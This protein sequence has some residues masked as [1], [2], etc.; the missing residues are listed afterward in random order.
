MCIRDRAK[1][2]TINDLIAGRLVGLGR[3]AASYNLEAI[4]A[5]FWIGA[6]VDGDTASRDG[7]KVI[8]VRIVNPADVP[9]IQP[10]PKSG[11]GRPSQRDL[12]FEAIADHRK[13]DPGLKRPRAERLRAY[14]SYISTK[15]YDPR[16][17][18]GFDVKTIEKYEAAIRRTFK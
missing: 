10:Q 2:A 15:G 4:D 17:D 8:D 7:A 14:R 3:P 9:S 5:S 18:A 16:I 1:T 13:T 11:L 6:A 12:I